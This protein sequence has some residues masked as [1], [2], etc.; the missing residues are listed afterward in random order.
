[1]ETGNTPT[2][3]PGTPRMPRLSVM[4]P[5]R[6]AMSAEAPPSRRSIR[7]PGSNRGGNP[8]QQQRQGGLSASGRK[9]NAATTPHGRAAI[10]ALDSRRAAIFTPHRDRRRSGARAQ[11]ETPRDDL[12]GLSRLLARATKPIPSSSSPGTT[13][14]SEGPASGALF[15]DDDDDLP[16]APRLSLPIDVDDDD[17]D[18]H[19]HRSAGLEDENFTMQSIEMPRRALSEQ[20]G[21]RFSMASVRVSDFY[22]A[23]ALRSDD[24]GIDS[25]FF[26]PRHAI[27]EDGLALA[28]EDVT[29]ERYMQPLHFCFLEYSLNVV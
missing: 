20:P 12:R 29:Y 27:D 9:V 1:M 13:V 24:V 6:R 7:T 21:S 11:R 3:L 17:D 10:R 25:A 22:A 23:N 4:T 5:G 26:P 2:G 16:R 28:Q 18:L 19:P 15:E 8:Q 14:K